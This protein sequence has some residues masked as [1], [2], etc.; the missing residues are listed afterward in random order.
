MPSKTMK[1]LWSAVVSRLRLET[2]FVV[3]LT[4]GLTMVFMRLKGRVIELSL[5]ESAFLCLFLVAV[6]EVMF[7]F[8]YWPWYRGFRE[9]VKYVCINVLC[10][11]VVAS[12]VGKIAFTVTGIF[13]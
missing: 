12:I 4:F 5:I 6:L 8:L 10:E 3:V 7:A 9:L 13:V 11:W 1:H 2:V